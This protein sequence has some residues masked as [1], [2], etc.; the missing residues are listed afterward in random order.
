MSRLVLTVFMLSCMGVGAYPA[1]AYAEDIPPV[2]A[3]WM[4]RSI[5]PQTI[6]KLHTLHEL[7]NWCEYE[8]SQPHPNQVPC[9]MVQSLVKSL[10]ESHEVQDNAQLIKA[11]LENLES[12]P[13]TE[14]VKE[15]TAV[16]KSAL[17]EIEYN[18]SPMN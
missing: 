11:T 4:L 6:S 9:E 18:L 1:P 15:H 7:M 16:L 12:E 10:G 2:K 5:L 3:A 17:E 8:D 14:I 13:Q